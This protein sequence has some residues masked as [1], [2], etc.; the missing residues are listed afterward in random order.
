FSRGQLYSNKLL[1]EF[2][3]EAPSLEQLS[4]RSARLRGR[5]LKVPG[6]E[7][8]YS[9]DSPLGRNMQ[10]HRGPLAGLMGPLAEAVGS[11]AR[12]YYLAEEPRALLF[13]LMI[14]E[15]PFSVEAMDIVDQV[16]AIATEQQAGGFASARVHLAGLTPYI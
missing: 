5:F 3:G 12:G 11:S 8:V 4:E 13:D 16:R 9:L 10:A 2:G 15:P 6:V 14:D 7:D 1:I